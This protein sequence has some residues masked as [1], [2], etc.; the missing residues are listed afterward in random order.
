MSIP[1]SKIFLFTRIPISVIHPPSRAPR[2]GDAH[3]TFR[4]VRDAV[5]AGRRSGDPFIWRNA[6]LRTAKSCGS[7]AA[8][9]ASI[10][11]GLCWRGNG[12]N[13]GRSPGRARISR[14]A[15]ARGKPG[16]PGCTCQNRVRHY[17]SFWHTAM[18]AQSAPGFP[19]ALFT[20]EGQGRCT[21]RAKARRGDESA[22]AQQTRC[23]PGQASE[24]P[25]RRSSK[26]EGGSATRDP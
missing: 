22:C 20:E 19:C 1:N 10:R 12:D 17:P 5:A 25:V 14:K 2:R 6:G 23:R 3:R 26:S 13:K 8:T 18:R 15:I 21:T 16:C 9:L 24:A 4:W 7:G 11:A